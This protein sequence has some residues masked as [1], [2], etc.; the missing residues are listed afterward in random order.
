MDQTIKPE[1]DADWQVDNYGVAHELP[2]NGAKPEEEPK[3]KAQLLFQG[4]LSPKK[5]RKII[6]LEQWVEVRIENGKTVTLLVPNNERLIRKGQRM[7]PPPEYVYRRFN[8]PSG[9]P[10]EY[11]WTC[12]MSPQMRE[13]GGM[14]IQR[15]TVDHWLEMMEEEKSRTDGHVGPAPDGNLPR[16][17]EHGDCDCPVCTHNRRILEER[18]AAAEF[19]SQN[20]END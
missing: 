10:D 18:K 11:A 8:F 17:P 2:T 13:H 6:R 3:T 5:Q 4:Q 7:W 19:E 14:G 15:M 12:E 9:V 20:E 1:V 16:P